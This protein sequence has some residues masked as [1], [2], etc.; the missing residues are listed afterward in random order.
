MD[1]DNDNDDQRMSM[2]I[3]KNKSLWKSCYWFFL[4]KVKYFHHVHLANENL[5]AA[6]KTRNV[7]YDFLKKMHKFNIAARKEEKRVKL[8]TMKKI[9]EKCIKMHKNIFFLQSQCAV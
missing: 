4:V 5:Q 6:M 3:C 7:N 2:C 1:N 9:I 8:T